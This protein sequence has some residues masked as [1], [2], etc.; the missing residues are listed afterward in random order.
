[1]QLRKVEK[2]VIVDVQRALLAALQGGTE[3]ADAAPSGM[4]VETSDVSGH[5]EMDVPKVGW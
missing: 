3:V 2:N 4:E 5:T 1:M